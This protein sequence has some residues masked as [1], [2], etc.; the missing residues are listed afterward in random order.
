[1]QKAPYPSW[2]HAAREML[3]N[4]AVV[5][6]TERDVAAAVSGPTLMLGLIAAFTGPSERS[7]MVASATVL[8]AFGVGFMAVVSRA[9]LRRRSPSASNA[10]DGASAPAASRRLR[11]IH[12]RFE[13]FRRAK[14]KPTLSVVK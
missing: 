9:L 5:L 12:L 13:P 10:V 6:W 1:M 7:V 11:P 14:G 4:V 2:P 3:A 8:I